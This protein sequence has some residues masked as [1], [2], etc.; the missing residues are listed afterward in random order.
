[1]RGKYSVE[2]T[3]FFDTIILLMTLISSF[4]EKKAFKSRLK[5]FLLYKVY[6]IYFFLSWL[7]LAAM[8]VI[9]IVQFV[10]NEEWEDLIDVMHIFLL[11][12]NGLYVAFAIQMT[13][14]NFKNTMD[15]VKKYFNNCKKTTLEDIKLVIILWV[16]AIL[17][18][19]LYVGGTIFYGGLLVRIWLPNY[20]DNNL[21]WSIYLAMWLYQGWAA[22][23]IV[24]VYGI[25]A[26]FTIPMTQLVIKELSFLIHKLE[27]FEYRDDNSKESLRKIHLRI[28]GDGYDRLR[29]KKVLEKSTQDNDH[30]KALCSSEE[31]A[32]RFIKDFCEYHR[33]IKK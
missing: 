29:K 22:V 24:L 18:F 31:E 33:N 7:P 3:T 11:G 8:I 28:R 17:S 10:N 5:S 26:P 14:V 19:T 15:N 6:P 1:M 4:P 20:D 21:P 32:K 25:I 13:S 12:I 16:L 30:I 9:K 23:A 2:L 27:E